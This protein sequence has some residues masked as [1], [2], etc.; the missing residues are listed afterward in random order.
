MAFETP[1]TTTQVNRKLVLV[2]LMIPLMLQLMGTAM[3]DL[4]LP[5]MKEQFQITISE[6]AW[7]VTAYSLPSVVLMPLYGRLGDALGKRKM[8]V[9]G[10]MLF[11]VGS[12][13]CSLSTSLAWLVAGRLLQGIGIAA[14]NPLAMAIIAEVFPLE[15][16]GTVLGVWL[17]AAPISSF[18]G[19]LLGGLLIEYMG[20]RAVFYPM[21]I[22]AACTI[23]FILRNTPSF[24]G[25][26][27]L[28]DFDWG[29]ALTFGAALTLVLVAMTSK[30]NPG[31]LLA[32]RTQLGGL[33]VMM[34]AVFVMVEIRK[35]NPFVDLSMFKDR[36]FSIVV[37]VSCLR[38]A[39]VVGNSFLLSLYLQGMQGLTPSQ[40]GMLFVARPF[41]S[42]FSTSLS[43]RLADWWGTR[44]PSVIGLGIM[45][46]AMFLASRLPT[47]LSYGY[48]MMSLGLL[49]LG[50]G[51]CLPALSKAAMGIF[52]SERVGAASGLYSMGRSLGVAS[53]PVLLGVL[54][55]ERITTYQQETQPSAAQSMPFREMFWIL[56]ALGIVATAAAMLIEEKP[57]VRR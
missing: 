28:G 44:F 49:G 6:V 2:S 38:M 43:G 23:L 4:A 19:P 25:T 14:Q 54:L 12:G 20:W 27:S 24:E 26:G 42:V 40:T 17:S 18:F 8:Y 13:L 5:T 11:A 55:T 50:M 33:G 32:S 37:I 57:R 10:L 3:I 52:D 35:A 45:S 39:I 22:G 46:T 34:L 7:I 51:I 1:K 9:S 16:R 56:T 36:T 47:P 41:V 29:G 30:G 31:S 21:T 15:Q 48:V 53:S